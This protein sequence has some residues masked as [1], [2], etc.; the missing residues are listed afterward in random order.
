L[1]V[2]RKRPDHCQD[3]AIDPYS[4]DLSDIF[5]RVAIQIADILKG[6]RPQDIPVYEPTKF[7]LVV[8][9]KTAKSLGI[10]VPPSIVVSASEVIE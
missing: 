8:N 4:T 1:E 5:R 9:I 7:E 6:T 10:N 3:N 2:D